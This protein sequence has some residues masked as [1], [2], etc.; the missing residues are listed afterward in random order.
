MKN[1]FA[2]LLF[3]LFTITAT[4][5]FTACGASTE[6]VE[7]PS[8]DSNAISEKKDHDMSG[9]DH[10]KMDKTNYEDGEKHKADD[11]SAYKKGETEAI[12]SA[13]EQIDIS[14]AKKIKTKPSKVQ[15]L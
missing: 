11:F 3:A 4:I 12:A 9:M 8:T 10:S 14:L 6:K 1:I 13:A 15:R 5:G 2:G 7:T